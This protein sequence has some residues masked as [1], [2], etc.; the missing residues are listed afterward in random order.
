MSWRAAGVCTQCYEDVHMS[1]AAGVVRGLELFH[2]ASQVFV[3]GFQVVDSFVQ[4]LHL[5][6]GAGAEFFDDLLIQSSESQSRISMVDTSL[7]AYL[8]NTPQTQHHHKRANLLQHA[9]EQDVDDEAR[10]DDCSV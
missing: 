6:F 4:R 8:H 10:R 9:L 3:F 7:E 2:F 5:L 1:N